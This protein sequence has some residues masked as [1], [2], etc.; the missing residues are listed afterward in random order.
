MLIFVFSLNI[1]F[2]SIRFE[3]LNIFL[4]LNPDDKHKSPFLSKRVN[5]IERGINLYEQRH[6]LFS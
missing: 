2:F 1:I 5:V 6:V 4:D 3:Q